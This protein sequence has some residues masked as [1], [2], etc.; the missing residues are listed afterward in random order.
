MNKPLAPSD[1]L[2]LAF[3]F[4]VSYIKNIEK[5]AALFIHFHIPSTK[6]TTVICPVYFCVN[7]M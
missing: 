5:Y 1:D 7:V 2:E 3:Y 4:I 6:E